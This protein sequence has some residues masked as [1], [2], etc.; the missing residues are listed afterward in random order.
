MNLFTN[1]MSRR[2]P[3]PGCWSERSNP[4]DTKP[5]PL[6]L[7]CTPALPCEKRDIAFD[8]GDQ[9]SNY[10]EEYCYWESGWGLPPWW[11]K[12]QLHIRSSG[13]QGVSLVE[14]VRF[15]YYVERNTWLHVCSTNP[16]PWMPHMYCLQNHSTQDM[17]AGRTNLGHA[18]PF[19]NYCSIF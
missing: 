11:W 15:A 5:F 19:L 16:R 1:A 12:T 18:S 4:F 2:V 3:V 14:W 10:M 17:F 8:I 7:F 9:V 13:Q 6:S